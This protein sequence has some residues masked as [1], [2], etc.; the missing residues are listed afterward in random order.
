MSFNGHLVPGETDCYNLQGAERKARFTNPINPLRGWQ[1]RIGA[2]DP[3]Q[4][5]HDP[6]GDG[7]SFVLVALFN[8]L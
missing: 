2:A 1:Q 3:S 7:E 5:S 8:N 4:R 6:F